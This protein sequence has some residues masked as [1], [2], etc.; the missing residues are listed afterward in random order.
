MLPNDLK[1]LEKA[2]NNSKPND[3]F[4]YK[5]ALAARGESI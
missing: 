3:W 4:I 5:P 1:E 2:M